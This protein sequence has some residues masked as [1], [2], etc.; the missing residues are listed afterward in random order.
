[1]TVLAEKDKRMEGKKKK[2]KNKKEK[3]KNRGKR[4][5]K[6]KRKKIKREERVPLDPSWHHRQRAKSKEILSD[7]KG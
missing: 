3:R 4:D 7:G 2:M 5:Q 1:M 6:K